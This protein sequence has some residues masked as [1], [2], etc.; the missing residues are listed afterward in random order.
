MVF[1]PDNPQRQQRVTELVTQAQTYL[2]QQQSEYAGYQAQIA[3]ANNSIA[4]AYKAG[5]LS[6]PPSNALNLIQNIPGYSGPGTM[7]QIIQDLANL[8][9]FVKLSGY[10]T[11]GILR[12]LTSSGVLSEETAGRVLVSAFGRE[13]TAGALASSL[14]AGLFAGAAVAGVDLIIDAIE[15]AEEKSDLDTAIDEIFPMRAYIYYCQQVTAPL[16]SSLTSINTTMATVSSM[17]V[18]ITQT[19]IQDLISK[20]A[21]PGI[22]QAQAVTMES[23]NRQLA[24]L[25][26]AAGSYTADDPTPPTTFNPNFGATGQ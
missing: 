25:D 8:V 2:Q 15:G 18:P 9:G 4:S 5:G 10:L 26:Q 14:A 23:V 20:S 19:F 16:L 1:Y 21:N 12:G 6:V 22:Q 17:G 11:P 7:V 3:L 24:S 13:L